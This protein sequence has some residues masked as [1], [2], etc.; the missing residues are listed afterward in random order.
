VEPTELAGRLD[1]GSDRK[2]ESKTLS[3]C[4]VGDT[5]LYS[6]ETPK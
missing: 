6:A 2:G 3:I 4:S 5:A 1:M